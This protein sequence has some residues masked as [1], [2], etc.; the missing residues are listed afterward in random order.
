MPNPPA[1]INH[2]DAK[3]LG[4]MLPSQL[5]QTT[6]MLQVPTRRP[7]ITDV[8]KLCGVTPAT[9]SRVL[10]KKKEFSTTEAVRKK[11]WS[12]A[13]K[14]GYVPDLSAR[15]LS[16]RSTH[17]IGLFASPQTHVA[18]GINESLIE[19]IASVLHAANYDVFFELSPM[20]SDHPL[21]FWRFDGAIL[22][23]SP[24]PETVKEL[25]SRRVPYVCVNERIGHP[26]AQVLAD[27][28][29]G[30]KSAVDHLTKLGHK[31][32][33]YANA[34]A[35]YFSH[36]SVNERYDTLL[37]AARE[38]R[39]QLVPGH[40]IPFPDPAEFL[41]HAVIEGGATAIITYDHRIGVMILGAAHT[42]GMRIP[43][44]VSLICFNDVFPVALLNPP[45]TSVAVAGGEMG[46]LGADLLLSSLRTTGRPASG[47][48]IRVVEDLVIRG[49]TAP[50]ASKT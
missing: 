34:R 19:G 16:R 11:I 10:N 41:R 37:A 26:V 23:Q 4:R 33:A 48:E 1:P 21:P 43:T 39:M 15:N 44:D 2:D 50:P 5:R 31:R 36:Y 27:D 30:M 17:I 42:L 9:V 45:L 6:I 25:D 46:R 28:A 49:S 38:K 18:E 20:Q 32:I 29:M 14:V 7:T 22:M 24:K 40:E 12:T 35:G 13:S 8:A 3:P 47:A